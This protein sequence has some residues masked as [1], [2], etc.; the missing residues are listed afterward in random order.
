MGYQGLAQSLSQ[1]LQIALG[2]TTADGAITLLPTPC[3]GACDHAPVAMVGDQ[4]A[5]QLT[6]TSLIELARQAREQSL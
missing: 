6:P 1:E 4:R 2:E 3:L 5:H